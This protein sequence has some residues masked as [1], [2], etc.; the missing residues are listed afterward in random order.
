MYNL[1]VVVAVIAA[2]VGYETAVSP[3]AVTAA[4]FHAL[5]KVKPP[6]AA[7]W[8]PP[9][10]EPPSWLPTSPLVVLYIWLKLLFLIMITYIID[11]K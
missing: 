9:L 1:K 11:Y 3:A 8:E 4:S 2:V 7:T 5:S 10:I 6:V